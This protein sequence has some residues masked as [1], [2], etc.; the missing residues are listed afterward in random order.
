MAASK[1]GCWK[2]LPFKRL[3][4]YIISLI[5]HLMICAS[6]FV[7]CVRRKKTGD[8]P[9]ARSCVLDV[10][11]YSQR[12][13][14]PWQNPSRRLVIVDR[15]KLCWNPIFVSVPINPLIWCSA[16]VQ[17]YGE[18]AEEPSRHFNGGGITWK[19]TCV[20]FAQ[21]FVAILLPVPMLNG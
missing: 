15:P 2:G 21:S 7:G 20:Q 11:N 19:N 6:F 17:T 12:F 1:E 14:L 16:D 13:F 10:Q 4:L 9:L 18:C 8:Y 3:L 5:I